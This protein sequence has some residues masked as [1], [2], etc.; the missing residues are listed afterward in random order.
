MKEFNGYA[1]ALKRLLRGAS[2]FL[3]ELGM[4]KVFTT[5]SLNLN[6]LNFSIFR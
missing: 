5:L 1:G 6:Y 3:S 4:D 2:M